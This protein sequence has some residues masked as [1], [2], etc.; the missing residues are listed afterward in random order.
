MNC[1]LLIFNNQIEENNFVLD[2][3]V[4]QNFLQG[5]AMEIFMNQ[6]NATLQPLIFLNLFN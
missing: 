6:L 5:Y 2:H 1:V 4:V 3:T